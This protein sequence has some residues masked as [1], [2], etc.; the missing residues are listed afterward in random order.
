LSHST[1]AAANLGVLT[2]LLLCQHSSTT[3]PRPLKPFDFQ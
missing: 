2:S 3:C 1:A